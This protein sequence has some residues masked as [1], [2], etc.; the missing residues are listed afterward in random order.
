MCGKERINSKYEIIDYVVIFDDCSK[1]VRDVRRLEIL[2]KTLRHY[3]SFI[4]I[5]TQ[6]LT[7]LSPPLREASNF[8]LLFKGIGDSKLKKFWDEKIT[9]L[10]YEEFKNIYDNITDEKY[11]FL[12]ID[13]DNQQFRK[14]LD[15][16]IILS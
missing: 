16:L 14:N 10:N 13:V 12:F 8:C 3:N 5:A 4:F 1:Y 9:S 11:Q 2:A 15:Q 6:S 7:D